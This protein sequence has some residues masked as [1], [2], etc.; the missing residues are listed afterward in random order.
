MIIIK[1]PSVNFASGEGTMRVLL[2]VLSLLAS[3]VGVCHDRNASCGLWASRRYCT[4]GSFIHYM[5]RYCKL[6]CRLCNAPE[7]NCGDKLSS[8]NHWK[9]SGECTKNPGFMLKMCKRSCG[10]CKG[11]WGDWGEWS[12]CIGDCGHKKRE[13]ERACFGG[14]CTGSG[15]QQESCKDEICVNEVN[16]LGTSADIEARV[17]PKTPTAATVALLMKAQ[18]ELSPHCCS[19]N[20][21]K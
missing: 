11:A 14:K 12:A 16:K 1:I 19:L 7:S 15:V 5:H 4:R 10:N 18:N 6:S 20:F 2:L 13:R 17:T 8:C 9:N 21:S 3:V